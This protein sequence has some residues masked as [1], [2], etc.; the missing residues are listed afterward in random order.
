MTNAVAGYGTLLKRGDG[1]VGAAVQ[2]SRTIGTSNSQI[3]IKAKAGVLA[4]AGA[5]GNTMSCQIVV[6]GNNTP[7][8]V[9]VSGTGANASLTINS[10]TNGSAVATSTINDIIAAIDQSATADALFDAT[11]GAGNGTGV[12]AAAAALAFLASGSNG[13]EVFTSVAEVMSV[14][15]GGL[16]LDVTEATHMESPSKWR[17]FIATVKDAGD[18]SFEINFQPALAG[19]QG[20]TTDLKNQTLRNWQLVFPDSGATTWSF[21]GFVT[22]FAP[23]AQFDGKLTASCSIKITGAPTI[24]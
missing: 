14:S 13:G 3:V 16:K 8:S 9:S 7:L 15:A 21:G 6:S 23:Q 22:S 10:A 4:L 2:A 11:S 18:V 19:H 20:L 12:L 5:L 17:E 1:G 24:P